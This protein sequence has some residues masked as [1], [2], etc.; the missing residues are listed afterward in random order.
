MAPT[1]HLRAFLGKQLGNGV[2]LRPAEPPGGELKDHPERP[3]SVLDGALAVPLRSHRRDEP[4]G[5]VDRDRVH[6][7]VAEPRPQ[8]EPDHLLVQGDRL[9]ALRR[10]GAG[11]PLVSCLAEAE[12]RVRGVALAAV[13]GALLL[14]ELLPRRHDAAAGDLGAA[15]LRFGVA[16]GDL[17]HLAVLGLPRQIPGSTFSRTMLMSSAP[18]S[19]LGTGPGVWLHRPAAI[20]E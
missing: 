18:P 16:P 17:V 8:M 1:A 5:V 6:A 13:A 11:K 12:P 3:L 20:W 19:L 7:A 14:A 2:D 9:R 15:L 4:G 10:H